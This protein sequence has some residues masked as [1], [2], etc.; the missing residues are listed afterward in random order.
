MS[1]AD[2]ALCEGSEHAGIEAY[3]PGEHDLDTR[4]GGRYRVKH[5]GTLIEHRPTP[6][7]RNQ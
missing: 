5:D 7:D 4:C 2:R 3:S 6:A 1:P